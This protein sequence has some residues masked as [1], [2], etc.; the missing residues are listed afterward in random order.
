M[1]DEI[2][3]VNHL[4]EMMAALHEEIARA[5]LLTANDLA[6]TYS[7]TAPRD[8]GFMA[9][10]AYTVTAAEGS[11]YDGSGD[12]VPPVAERVTNDHEAYAAVA[13]SYAAYPELGTVH[14]AAQPAFYPAGDKAGRTYAEGLARVGAALEKLSVKE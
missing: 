9:D 4:P 3:I 1:A 2:R 11:T 6:A 5:I 13:A 14:Q 10:S 12:V 8:T 7:A